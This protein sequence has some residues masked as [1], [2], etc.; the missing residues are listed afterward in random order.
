[1]RVLFAALLIGL[2]APA[3]AQSAI[4]TRA[5]IEGAIDGY[6]RPSF[7]QL[8]EE[9]GSLE[10]NIKALCTEPSADALTLSQN[11][12]RSTVIAFSRAEFL[13]IGPLGVG[14]Q[15]ERL[16][17]WP[18]RKGIALRQVQAALAEQDPTAATAGTL[19]NK[20]VA[21]QGLVA[22][23]YLLFGTGSEQLAT[24]DGAYRCSYAAASATL[25]HGLAGTINAEWQDATP[26]GAAGRLLNPQP[27][28]DDYRTETEVLEKLAATLIHGTEAIRDQ[29]VSPI[30]SEAPGAPKPKSALFWRSGMTVPAL[31]ADFAGLHDFFVAAKYPEAIGADN[32][33]VANGAAFEFQNAARA[34]AAITEPMEQAVADP[35]QLQ[36]LKYLVII[37]GSLDT[38]LGQ[39]LAAALGLSVGFST[40][41]GD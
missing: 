37:T 11:Q 5:I 30:L 17:F 18:D 1:M 34:A 38:L 24:A 36:A 23:E 25:I 16:L 3:L 41:D 32:E 22:L 29:R 9:S 13:R 19:A 4:P 2:S 12:F 27:G 35:K 15:L 6:I 20:S 40:L 7:A 39:N 14:D 10:T 26:G 28:Y 33:W 31:A 8:A 21:M